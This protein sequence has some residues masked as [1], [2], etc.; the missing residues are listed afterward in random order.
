MATKTKTIINDKFSDLLLKVNNDLAITNSLD[1]ALESLVGITTSIIKC[2]RGT[3]FLNDAKSEELYSRVAQGNF[4]REIRFMNSKGVAGWS[5]TNKKGAIVHDAYKDDRFNKNVDIRT[6]FR[7]KSILCMPLSTVSGK[8]IGVSQLLNK[9]D[10]QFSEDDLEIVEAM[11]KQAAIAIQSHVALEQME[12]AR[13]KELEFMDLVSEIS[14]ELELTSLLS[15][16]IATITTMLEAERS[17]LFINDEKT[18]E[19]FT[20]V[21]EGLSQEIRFPNHM[22]IAGHVFTS[23]ETVNIPHA[24]ADLRFNPGVDKSTGFFTRSMLCAPVTNKDGKIIGV[25]QVLNKQ[26]GGFTDEDVSRL[27]AFTSQISIGIENASLFDN[28]QSLMNYNE[29][30]LNSMSNGVITIDGE[31]IIEKCNPAGIKILKMDSEDQVIKQEFKKIFKGKNKWIMEKIKEV[32]DIDFIADAEL[33]FSGEKISCNLTIM[34]LTGGEKESLGILIMIEDI[35]NEKRMK[36]TMSRYMD[37]DLADQ[38]LEA[39]EGDNVMGGKESIGTVLFS[40]IR[41]FTTLTESLGAQG[42]VGF[43]NDYFSVMVD[44]IQKEGGM[45][46]KF[47]GDAIMAI[48]GT[49]VAHDD[50][51]DRGL[52]AAIDMM[53]GLNDFNEKRKSMG[54]P[55]V[56]HGMG[57]NTDEIVSGNIGSPKRMDYTV[58]GDGVNLAAR[59]ESSCKKYGAKILMSEFTFRALKATY[60]TRQVDN[61]IVKGKTEPVRVYEVLDFHSKESFPNMIEV[62]EMFNNGI[63]YYNEGSWDK[64]IVQFKKAQKGNPNDICSKMYTERCEVLKK[65]DPKDWDGV[66]VATT[67]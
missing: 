30:M 18:N 57:L 17:S 61:I 25:S 16:I 52:R 43:L 39:G 15:K 34:P 46:D 64:A 47:I 56:D 14:S 4:M 11:T 41:S 19:L 63:E 50:D 12:E 6:G 48:F 29:S 24:Y 53:H 37:A 58:I 10:G 55:P 21:G 2:E 8:V 62:L 32:E 40:D 20:M 51:P 35:S 31:G 59:V 42:T 33:E 44:C 66:W 7:T 60:R 49:P 65:R 45:L 54:L 36:S 27:T 23:G 13:K 28:I 22:G 38:L 67:K 5:Y 1:E 26:G 3:I 9:L